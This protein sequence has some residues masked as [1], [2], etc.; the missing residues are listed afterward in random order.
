[1][2]KNA[3]ILAALSKRKDHELVPF[4]DEKGAMQILTVGKVKERLGF[5]KSVAV[6][7]AV[8]AEAQAKRATKKKVLVAPKAVAKKKVVRKKK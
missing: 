5:T 4:M 1:M 7:P 3:K 2:D 8:V 6:V